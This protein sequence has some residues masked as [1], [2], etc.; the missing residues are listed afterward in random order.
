VRVQVDFLFL[1]PKAKRVQKLRG[2]GM[3]FQQA[4]AVADREFTSDGLTLKP[5]SSDV[6]ALASGPS[7]MGEVQF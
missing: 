3:S 4:F 6:A 7:Q 1:T 5:I 2:Q